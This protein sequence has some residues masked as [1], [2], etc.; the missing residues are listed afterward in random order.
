[1]HCCIHIHATADIAEELM[2]LAEEGG[3]PIED[4]AIFPIVV[5]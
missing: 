1:L 5:S 3:T 2:A 4:P